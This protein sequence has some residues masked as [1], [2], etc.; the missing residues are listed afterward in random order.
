MSRPRLWARHSTVP[1]QS[2][3]SFMATVKL[4]GN[5]TAC[6]DRSMGHATP[7]VQQQAQVHLGV[8][9]PL[10]RRHRREVRADFSH[11]RPVRPQQAGL[12]TTA[13]ISCGRRL[14]HP[15]GTYEEPC[16]VRCYMLTAA[17]AVSERLG[18]PM[19][20]RSVHA[21]IK[22]VIREQY[23]DHRDTCSKR[24]FKQWLVSA[25]R[26]ALG[27][28][29]LGVLEA[30]QTEHAGCQEDADARAHPRARC[31]LHCAL[32]IVHC[33]LCIVHCELCIWHCSSCIVLCVLRCC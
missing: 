11:F 21:A 9:C 26:L 10:E 1:A 23:L 24:E 19:D 15:P 12:M 6:T 4:H 20:E 30:P 28:R 16:C 17:K 32:C 7:A 31:V 29:L 22:K 2:W 33:A 3:W 13:C 27:K 14:T 18:V 25:D 5:A 8:K